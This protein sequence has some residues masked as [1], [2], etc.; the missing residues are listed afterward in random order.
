LS[1]PTP[2]SAAALLSAAV[3][4]LTARVGHWSPG[5]WAAG[6]RADL[7][8]GLAQRLADAGADVEG[9][10]RRPVPRLEHD[11]SLTDQVRVLAADLMLAGAPEPI[12]REAADAVLATLR[13]L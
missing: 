9:R 8:F 6:S 13:G 3:D 4:R 10:S 5:R 12:L 1:V 2:G 11:A 7:V